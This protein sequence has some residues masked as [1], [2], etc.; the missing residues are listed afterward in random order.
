[1]SAAVSIAVWKPDRVLLIRRGAP[2]F[3]G[4]W[5]FPGGRVESGETPVEAV[6]RE[7]LEETSLE[8]A[9]PSLVRMVGPEV[10]GADA[11][12][13]VYVA[14]YAGGTPEARS[15]AAEVGWFAPDETRSLN[16]TPGLPAILLITRA[17]LTE[18]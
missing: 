3:G 4:L 14:R 13:A 6:R 16:T 2:P 12:I 11:V 17:A 8:V 1:M 18:A 10:T 9:E 15:D 7:L 5:S